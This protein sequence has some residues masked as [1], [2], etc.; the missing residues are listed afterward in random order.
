MV[1]AALVL[2]AELFS[3][4]DKNSSAFIRISSFL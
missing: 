3:P 4:D 1:A 2:L